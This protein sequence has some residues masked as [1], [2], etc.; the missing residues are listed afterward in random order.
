MM[1]KYAL[2][3]SMLFLGLFT[4]ST[5]AQ[6][7]KVGVI[8]GVNFADLYME[9]STGTEFLTSSKTKPAAGLVADLQLNDFAHISIEPMYL[10]KGAVQ[11]AT[12]EFPDICMNMSFIEMPVFFKAAFGDFVRPYIKAGPS[13]GILI[14]SEGDYESGGVVDGGAL[15]TYKTDLGD[16]LQSIDFSVSAGAGLS[17]AFG[18]N[19][20]FV[21][22]RY[23]HGLVDLWKG[24]EIEWKSG[25]EVIKVDAVEEAIVRTHGIQVLAGIVFPLTK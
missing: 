7:L 1:K 24:G 16:V 19:V 2:L 3:I 13:I 18:Q 22:G 11:K 23:S 5:E 8:G 20:V 15:R 9:S 14:D 17:L 6:E 4:I 10:G 21:E 25:D 12:E